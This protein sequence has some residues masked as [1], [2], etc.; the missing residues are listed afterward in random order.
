[1]NFFTLPNRTIWLLAILFVFPFD[2]TKAQ[3][4]VNDVTAAPFT[5]Q[6][7]I[8]NVFLG[9]GVDVTNINFQGVPEAVGYFSGGAQ[10]I[11]I[12]RGIVLTTGYVESTGGLFG[13][14]GVEEVGD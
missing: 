5:P 13:V 9:Q 1:M 4:Q 7:L 10:R 12:D 3:M 2:I 8:S 11:G 14:N 6:N